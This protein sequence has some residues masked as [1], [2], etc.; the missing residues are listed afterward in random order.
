MPTG[1][2]CSGDDASLNALLVGDAAQR[3]GADLAASGQH[4]AVGSV[5]GMVVGGR[6]LERAGEDL[7]ASGLGDVVGRVRALV[8]DAR[9]LQSVGE[10][11]ASVDA[12]A[13]VQL[14]VDARR[15]LVG[16]GVD[17]LADNSWAPG[18]GA[19]AGEAIDGA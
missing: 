4:D 8:V 6:R 15:G 12:V 5:P 13:G 19:T 1:P 3:G 18:R 17:G 2:G 9:L 14:V 11:V 16:V 7:A 10:Q